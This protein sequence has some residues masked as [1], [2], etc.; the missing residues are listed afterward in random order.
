[1]V[2]LYFAIGMVV[3]T[4]LGAVAMACCAAAGNAEKLREELMDAAEKNA[5]PGGECPGSG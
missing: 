2:W 1:M 4:C 5:P 3:G